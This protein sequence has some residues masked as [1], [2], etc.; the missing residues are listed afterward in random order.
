M[1]TW[2]TVFTC[3]ESV[4]SFFRVVIVR[5]ILL[6]YLDT[7]LVNLIT[8]EPASET[9]KFPCTEQRHPRIQGL[10]RVECE[11]ES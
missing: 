2:H 7:W 4:Y 3:D 1:I 11:V 8:D 5:L 10:P 6:K 9:H